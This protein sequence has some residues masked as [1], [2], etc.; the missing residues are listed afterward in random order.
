MKAFY[1]IILTFLILLSCKNDPDP[2]IICAE[3]IAEFKKNTIYEGTISFCNAQ[4]P[5]MSF[6]PGIA[7]ASFIGS[8]K[9]QIQLVADSISFDTT[10]FFDI[11]CSIAEEVIPVITLDG[12]TV[13][14]EGYYTG[15]NR[16]I[17]IHFGY[18]NCLNNTAFNGISKQ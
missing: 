7:T 1:L 14:D 17:W 18:P 9:I 5:L 15:L 2:E 16:S 3:A 13:N 4:P 12:G 11:E 6:I 10:F 8:D